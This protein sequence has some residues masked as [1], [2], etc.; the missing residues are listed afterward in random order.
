MKKTTFSISNVGFIVLLLAVLVLI[1]LISINW[2]SRV[3]LT[4]G[5]IYSLSPA[6]K[7]AVKTLPDRLTVKCFFTKDLPPPYSS[8]SQFLKDK[9][10][11]YRAHSNGNFFFEFVDPADEQD[12][13]VQ[14]N[15]FQVMPIQLQVIQKE[16]IELKKCYMGVVFLYGDKS[17]TIPVVQTTAGLEYDITS[18]IKKIIADKIPRVGFLQGHGEPAPFEE[19]SGITGEMQKNYEISPVDLS[20]GTLV[21]DDLDALLIIRPMT[22]FSEW[23]IFAIDQYIMQGG[24]LGLMAGT[25]DANLQE[26]RATKKTLNLDEL[27][28]NL[29]FRINGDLVYDYQS[30]M[31]NIQQRQGF[32]TIQNAIPYPFFPIIRNFNKE[33]AIV[34]DLEEVSLYFPSS[35][36]TSVADRDSAATYKFEILARTSDKSNRQSGRFEINPTR[37]Q[38]KSLAFPMNGIPVAATVTGT[39][40]SL[41]NEREIPALPDG[42]SWEGDLITSS[43]ETRIVVV[44]DGK[45]GTDGYLS[46]RSN[47][48]FFQNIVDWLALDES[49]IHIRTREVTARPLAETTEG[50]KRVIKYSNIFIPAI[51]IILIGVIRW[52][53]RRKYKPEL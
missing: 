1:N 32:F 31:V 24:K 39:F 29:G 30:G 26:T 49:L 40:S 52:Q 5:R 42:G 19:M 37:P 14:A 48:N 11:E 9:L 8:N 17:E 15:S 4:E 35:I 47:A 6:S 45:F 16:K 43:P 3:D 46:T 44:G 38:F 33:N 21:P 34:R 7:E 18:T 50:M 28:A 53:I 20:Q 12:L 27:T 2:F 10:S 13:E 41:F 22:E 25:I 36:D 51:V 23:D